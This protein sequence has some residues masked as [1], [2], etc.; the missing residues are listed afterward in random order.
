MNES[1][2]ISEL[3]YGFHDLSSRSTIFRTKLI[4]EF[5]LLDN[6]SS[7]IKGTAQPPQYNSKD[8]KDNLTLNKILS[9]NPYQLIKF[10]A[11]KRTKE[12]QKVDRRLTRIKNINTVPFGAWAGWAVSS[13]VFQNLILFIIVLDAIIEGIAADYEDNRGDAPS[14]FDFTAVLDNVSLFLFVL[15]I[16]LRWADNFKQFWTDGWNIFDFL[17]T[18]V[19]LIPELI[20]LFT[21]SDK[22][23]ADAVRKLR[24]FRIFRALKAAVRFNNLRIIVSTI[25]EAFRSMAFIMILLSIVIYIFAIVGVYAFDTYTLSDI[26]GL[27]YQD[28]FSNLGCALQTLFQILTLDNWNNIYDEMISVGD[29]V[30]TA[31][32]MILWVWTGAFIFKNIFVGV[33]VNNFSKISSDLQE[34]REEYLKVKKMEKMR[35]KLKKELH[36]AKSTLQRSL[37]HLPVINEEDENREKIASTSEG[38]NNN[39]PEQT[40]A[41]KLLEDVQKMLI[42]SN[43]SSKEWENTITA[44]LTALSGKSEET[45]WPRD[46]LFKY[47]QLMERFQENLREYQE[48]QDL[49]CLIVL[50]FHDS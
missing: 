25:I 15:D 28:S 18:V 31:I 13:P 50:D 17:I 46:T 34:K 48:L 12:T 36:L 24:T 8:V 14:F 30:F 16:L 5:Q 9:E 1:D 32:F 40:S 26:P 19:T 23:I 29:S 45:L 43:G 42:E 10:Q 7:S 44:T 3:D 2:F 20:G 35:K 39:D 11:F 49:A 33:M 47:L 4:E 37:I 21:T 22:S 38:R 41:E 6:L 27:Q